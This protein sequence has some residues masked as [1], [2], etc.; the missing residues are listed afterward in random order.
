VRDFL[1]QKL[2]HTAIVVFCVLTLVFAG[3]ARWA[4]G[5]SIRRSST[6]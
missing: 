6:R 3:L 5:R 2:G 1:I 4:T